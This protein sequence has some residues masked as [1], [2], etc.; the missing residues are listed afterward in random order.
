M[1]EGCLSALL[2]NKTQ[3]LARRRREVQKYV[4]DRK[5]SDF[6]HSRAGWR[7]KGIVLSE[8]DQHK[9]GETKAKSTT[10]EG[11]RGRMVQCRN[12]G[13]N[14]WVTTAGRRREI[15]KIKEKGGLSRPA[16]EESKTEKL[17]Q[18]LSQQGLPSFS[19]ETKRCVFWGGGVRDGS[20]PGK[21]GGDLEKR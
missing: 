13:A 4:R 21:M 3:N 14:A 10:P 9:L 20:V 1:R 2:I 18:Q 5:A 16:R 19:K 8:C 12:I 17:V 11:T 7:A 15:E 6:G